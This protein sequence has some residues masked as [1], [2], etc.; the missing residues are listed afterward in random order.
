VSHEDQIEQMT[1]RIRQ[2]VSQPMS[3]AGIE[4]VITTSIG[5]AHSAGRAEPQPEALLRDA[6]LALDEAKRA[7]RNRAHLYS[8]DL[9]EA[10]G[11]RLAMAA[12]LRRGFADYEIEVFYQPVVSLADG[13]IVGAEALV[14]WNRPGVGVLLPDEWLPVAEETGLITRIGRE[15]LNVSCRRFATL[16]RRRPERPLR[17]AVNLSSTEMRSEQLVPAVE[18]ALVES[19]LDPQ[20][21][22]LE[23]SE[24]IAGDH[25]TVETLDALR[26]LGVRLSI[27]DF[28]TGYSAMGQLR[29]LP[30]DEIKVDQSFVAGLGSDTAD[31]AIV[32]AVVEL[33][34]GMSL[35]VVAEG[36][37]TEAQ[38][39]ELRSLGC[40]FAQGWLYGRAQPFA[41]FVRLLERM[42]ENPTDATNPTD[43]TAMPGFVA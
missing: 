30:V 5:V 4:V 35:D 14:R 22:L 17:V 29:R 12:D 9:A 18:H 1:D 39:D 32:R 8:D 42:D 31:S 40:P 41:R 38:A 13:L 26:A 28:G 15:T 43:T 21:L 2:E 25:R 37:T 10:S 20:L 6:D 3:L 27:D 16:N 24:Q 7:G 34:A 19:G 33:G 11:L 36:V 23:V